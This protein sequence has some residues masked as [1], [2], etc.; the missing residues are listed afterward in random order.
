[1]QLLEIML[2]NTIPLACISLLLSS[3]IDHS[4]SSHIKQ[5]VS[6][7][8]YVYASYPMGCSGQTWWVTKERKALCKVT[9]SDSDSGPLFYFVLQKAT[10]VGFPVD[11]LH[12][13]GILRSSFY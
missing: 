6:L 3:E 13:Y 5:D 11:F 4:K 2:R 10:G 8:V 1:M 12:I 7:Y 9:A